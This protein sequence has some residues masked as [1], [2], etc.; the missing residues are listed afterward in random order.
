MYVEEAHSW[1][2]KDRSYLYTIILRLVMDVWNEVYS[3]IIIC[4]IISIVVR[5][6]ELCDGFMKEVI[7]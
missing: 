7:I 3:S 1:H 2:H 4:G 5:T 6:S